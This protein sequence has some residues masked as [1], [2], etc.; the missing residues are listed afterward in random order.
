VRFGRKRPG[1]DDDS[2]SASDIEA[3]DAEGREGEGASATAHGPYDAS[4]VR[5]DDG[6]QRVDLGGLL[7]VPAVD[8][9]LRLQADE[10]TGTVS[11]VM[12]ATE[13]AALELRP[14]AAPKSG[15]LWD[16]VRPEIVAE[17][18][19]KGGTATETE[20]EHGPELRLQVPVRTPE[21]R[22]ALQVSR[23]VGVEGPRWFLRGT[24]L[25]SAATEPNQ[26]GPL[27]R[28]FR[29]VVVVRGQM[30]MPPRDALPLRLPPEAK[31]PEPGPSEPGSSVPGPEPGP[32]A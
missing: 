5:E 3:A 13:G 9:E 29:D 12:L 15:G 7:V 27:E 11:S 24:F 8:V 17:A 4:E 23:I 18:T 30:A 16:E 25:G 31:P 28:A 1:P 26:D 10:A 6:V 22:N 19:R 32:S 21:G 14:F 20:G 2:R